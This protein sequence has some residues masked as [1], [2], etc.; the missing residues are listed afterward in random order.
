MSSTSKESSGFART[1]PFALVALA[2]VW[3]ASSGAF[4]GATL[5]VGFAAL[6]FAA[7]AVA[8]YLRR[9]TAVRVGLLIGAV[10][11]L[12]LIGLC[13]LA[14]SEA[15]R[16]RD[17][18]IPVFIAVVLALLSLVPGA[19]TIA[20]VSA[21]RRLPSS[22]PAWLGAITVLIGALA[23][24]AVLAT[25]GAGLEAPRALGGVE[26]HDLRFSADGRELTVASEYAPSDNVFSVPDGRFV[27]AARETAI[28]HLRSAKPSYRSSDGAKALEIGYAKSGG[29]VEVLTVRDGAGNA[30]WSRRLG[31]RDTLAR[32]SSCC[33]VGAAAFSPDARQVAIAY[34]GTVY[35]YDAASG[36]EVAVLA[37]PG[38]YGR[39]PQ[40]PWWENLR[41]IF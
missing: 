3:M 1:V 34:F 12:A 15:F 7:L 24:L 10:M 6:L 40:P 41:R 30:L 35:L 39:K 18:G 14:L 23:L 31:L 16:V 8:V 11:T 2:L 5:A 28:R 33:L 29:K 20:G 21:L 22:L 26:V 32:G 9:P 25:F 38:R 27:R 36:A 4:A 13:A 19:M 37:G 17:N